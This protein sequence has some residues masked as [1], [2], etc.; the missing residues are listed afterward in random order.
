MYPATADTPTSHTTAFDPTSAHVT[1][2]YQDNYLGFYQGN[3]LRSIYNKTVKVSLL[4]RKYIRNISKPWDWKDFSSN[5]INNAICNKLAKRKDPR[6]IHA[7]LQI[8]FSWIIVLNVLIGEF[9]IIVTSNGAMVSN[10]KD[11]TI[12][13]YTWFCNKHK[14]HKTKLCFRSMYILSKPNTGRVPS[15]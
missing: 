15:F 13:F 14:Y 8:I 10:P 9:Q 5:Y 12:A 2:L 1:S 4:F 3:L 7:T 6:C 11:P